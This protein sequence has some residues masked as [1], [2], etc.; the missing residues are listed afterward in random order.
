[1]GE[2]IRPIWVALDR[3]PYFSLLYGSFAYMFHIEN[4]AALPLA[5][6]LAFMR[7]G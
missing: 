3:R 5:R 1:M 4:R 7:T 2:S 6:A